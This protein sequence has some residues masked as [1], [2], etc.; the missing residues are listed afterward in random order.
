M[1]RPC[2]ETQ[3]AAAFQQACAVLIAWRGSGCWA[4]FRGNH[5]IQVQNEPHLE[6]SL[7]WPETG[8]AVP[9]WFLTQGLC[10]FFPCPLN[11][12][13][14]AL[15][16]LTTSAIKWGLASIQSKHH[17]LQLKCYAQITYRIVHSFPFCSYLVCV[18]WFF[19]SFFWFLFP[20]LRTDIFSV[21]SFR[22]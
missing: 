15:W 19:S 13:R 21:L 22:S 4:P 1:Y 17:L 18:W 16:V 5:R 20:R 11:G 12:C 8:S 6:A 14:I 9:I 2:S 10:S 3:S 7:S